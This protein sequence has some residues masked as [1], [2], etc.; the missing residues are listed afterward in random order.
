MPKLV[1]LSNVLLSALDLLLDAVRFMRLSVRAHCALAAEN[2]FLRKQM[3][4]YLERK[5][6]PRLARDATRFTL[7]WLS[8]LFAWREALTIVKPDT[9]IRW[10]RKGFRLFWSWKS[11]ARAR[12]RVP[13]DL[14]KLTLQMVNYNPTWRQVLVTAELLLK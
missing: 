3:A 6:K 9:F 1:S 5:V 8:S 13:A 2:L 14:Q 4:V 10:H 11:K 12:P 7:V